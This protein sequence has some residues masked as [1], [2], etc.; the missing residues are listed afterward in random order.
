MLKRG[1][2]S[3]VCVCLLVTGAALGQQYT[4]TTAVGSGA[5]GYLDGSDLS[6]VQFSSPNAL[7]L[8]S[9]GAIYVSDSGNQRI[10]LISGGSA[11]TIAG[12]G[13]AGYTGNGSA[14]TSA[15]IQGPGGIVV[16]S[17][18]TIYIAETTNHVVRKIS[19]GTI[20]VYA[21]TATSGYGGDGGTASTA[22]INGPTGL[23]LDSSGSLYI[24][25]TGNNLI[26]KVTKDG[27][28]TS[29]VGGTGPTAGSLKNPTGICVDAAGT[30]YIADSGNRRIVKFA[31]SK[32]SAFA[33]NSNVGFSG[34]GGPA[35]SATFN[36]PVG[37]AVDSAGSVY[38][39]DT[40]NGRIRKVTPDG[41]IVTIASGLSFPRGVALTADG[42][43]YVAD[44]ANN[45]IRVLT[46]AYPTA[47][48][49][50][51]A[52]SF[53]SKVSPGALA[54][55]F[56]TGF[57]SVTA[58]GDL[59][60]LTNAL[61]TS[62]S[63]VGVTVN[64]VAAPLLFVSPGQINF[65]VPWKTPAGSASI[66]VVVN[67]GASNAL[68]VPVQTAA[69]GLF[70]TQD[71]AAIVQNAADYS[72]N[73]TD[74]PA[75]AGSTIIAYLTGSGS[76]S[77]AVTDGVPTPNSPLTQISASTSAKIGNANAQ[78]AFAGL[79]PGFV[80]LV[81]F[82]IVVPSGLAAGAYPLTVTIDGQTSNSGT[83]VVK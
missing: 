33:G 16:A 72:L 63:G 1:F 75:S 82:N 22:L 80:S 41:N 53:I 14:A 19:G 13:T 54:S 45:V 24:S 23:A 79:S 78:V 71:G 18:G 12:T 47:G 8:D 42:K 46:P 26:R 77:P 59:G 30:L 20:S 4:M 62:I 15:E 6:G 57:G 2:S 37:L 43:V 29:Y 32:L 48:G 83:I 39:A 51:N 58:Q 76:V 44:T 31:N 81:Q 5:A 25:D 52:A 64:G 11:S 66:A 21:G 36:N 34:D 50:T 73:G 55:I 49:A 35:T 68:D 38:I 56:G 65:Q 67:G 70:T 9:K 74:H 17:D 40:N 27:I 69:P 3:G 61:P 10:R 60:L 7:A 28:I